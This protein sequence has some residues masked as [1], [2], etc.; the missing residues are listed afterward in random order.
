[1]STQDSDFFRT[2]S[3]VLAALFV[4]FVVII[5]AALI[6]TDSDDSAKTASDPRIAAKVNELIAP[7]GK[8]NT[9]ASAAAA[10]APAAGGPI[11]AAAMFQSNCFACHGTGA[12]GAPKVGDKGAWKARIAKGKETLYKHAL[13]GFQGKSGVM[14]PKGGHAELSDDAIKA[15]VDH[16]VD[17]SK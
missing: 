15:I 7:V 5:V 14:P 11:D 17:K 16:M 6:I 13:H 3:L 9:D 10:P 2:L 1:V 12:A 8:V 4:F